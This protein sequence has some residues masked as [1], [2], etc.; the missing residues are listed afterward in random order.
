VAK[1]F[2]A[3]YRRFVEIRSDT[4]DLLDGWDGMGNFTSQVCPSKA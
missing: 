2:R 1:S 4:C 3:F